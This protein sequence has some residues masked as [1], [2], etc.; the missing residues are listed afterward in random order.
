MKLCFQKISHTWKNPRAVYNL[1]KSSL[2]KEV[3]NR[4]K[5]TIKTILINRKTETQLEQTA[6]LRFFS[7]ILTV[8]GKSNF[9][10][11]NINRALEPN[12]PSSEHATMIGIN[13]NKFYVV[14][15]SCYLVLYSC[16]LVLCHVVLVL[17]RFVLVLSRVVSLYTSVV[18]CCVVLSRVV[19][20]SYLCSFLD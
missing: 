12:I 5:D 3:S 1:L 17:F 8:T 16:C 11:Y 4:K 15:Y 13:Q 2:V 14:L 20:C 18:L 6:A 7:S 19:W 10:F 9:Q